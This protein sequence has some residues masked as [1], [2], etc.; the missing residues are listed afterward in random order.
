MDNKLLLMLDFRNAFNRINRHVVL[1]EVWHHFP[2]LLRW[3]HWCYG[4]SNQLHFN[5]TVIPSSNGV[6]QGDPL[7]PL[8][9]ALAI[10]PLANKLKANDTFRQ[11]LDL[12]VLYIDDGVLAGDAES[13]AASLRIVLD[14][15]ERLGLSLNLGKCEW[16]IAPAAQTHNLDA[17]FRRTLVRCKHWT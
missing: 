7:G 13:V 15:C 12:A 10:Q 14:E 3:V 4:R 9:F 1:S 2:V 8:L 6:Q 5:A 16:I 17:L 11:P